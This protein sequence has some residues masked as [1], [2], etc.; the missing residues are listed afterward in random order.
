VNATSF[1]KGRAMI[2]TVEATY[3]NGTLRPAEPLPLKESQKVL[4]TVQ[5]QPADILQAYGIL[6]WKGDAETVEH[7]A[8]APELDP[9]EES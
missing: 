3:E 2:L 9:Q 4:V 1:S 5:T 6:G 8:L 7:F